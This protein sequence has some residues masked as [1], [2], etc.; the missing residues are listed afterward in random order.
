MAVIFTST[1]NASLWFTIGQRNCRCRNFPWS[2]HRWNWKHVSRTW[3]I[4]FR[5]E[6][7]C[8]CLGMF[9][10][11][12]FDCFTDKYCIHPSLVCDRYRNC[13][14][15]S[16]EGYCEYSRWLK[17]RLDSFFICHS[18]SSINAS[19][20]RRKSG[21]LFCLDDH[22]IPSNIFH[23]RVLLMLWYCTQSSSEHDRKIT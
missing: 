2:S 4:H 7:N 14:N 6:S 19:L 13:P 5:F 16:D 15:H 12:G 8:W 21:P 18:R 3:S 22:S 1:L 20:V 11:C 9:S 10:S 23:H 17:I